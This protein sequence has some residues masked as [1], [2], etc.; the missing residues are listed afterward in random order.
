MGRFIKFCFRLVKYLKKKNALKCQIKL[1]ILVPG[2]LW[3]E[4]AKLDVSA[5]L[6][7]LDGIILELLVVLFRFIELF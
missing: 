1:D 6:D 7:L 4:L 2:R 3:F 5:V